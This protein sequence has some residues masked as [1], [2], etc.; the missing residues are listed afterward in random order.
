M[1]GRVKCRCWIIGSMLTL[2]LG[3]QPSAMGPGEMVSGSIESVEEG[4]DWVQRRRTFTMNDVPYG[5]TGLPILFYTPKSGFHYGGWIEVANYSKRPYQYRVNIQWWLSTLGMRNHHIRLEFPRI[6]VLPISLRFLT[7]DLKH[8]GANFF[9]IG[10]KTEINDRHV[11]KYPDYYRYLLEQQRSG[12]DI[13]AH[14]YGPITFFTGVRFNRGVP[15]RMDQTQS[16]DSYYVWSSTDAEAPG[17]RAGWANFS[18]TGLL[19]DRRDDQELPTKGTLSELSYQRSDEH[20]GSD[21]VSSRYTLLH[22]HYY[23]LDQ[24]YVLLNRVVAETMTGEAPFYELTEIGGSIRS[25]EVGGSAVLRGFEDRRFADKSKF[26]WTTELR[27]SFPRL[28][29]KAQYLQ[30]LAIAFFD[31]GRVAPSLKDLTPSDMHYSGGV[32]L[33]ATWNSQLS[34]RLDYAASKEGDRVYLRFGNLF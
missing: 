21:Y 31:F 27:R 13:E 28:T 16:E 19:I 15:T 4:V 24:K 1:V 33:R 6:W 7:Q 30:T 11:R 8:T 25:F 3:G 20:I 14:I 5:L 17:R 29:I 9:G 32:G 22:A 34:V 12:I 2:V 23:K 26:L 18:V 10:N